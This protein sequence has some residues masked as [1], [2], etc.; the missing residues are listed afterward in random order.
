MTEQRGIGRYSA[1]DNA[2]LSYSF[3]AW[4]LLKVQ[5][6][7]TNKILRITSQSCLSSMFVKCA[8]H[9][10]AIFLGLLKNYANLR[11]VIKICQKLISKLTTISGLTNQIMIIDCGVKA[12]SIECQ[13]APFPPVCFSRRMFFP[14]ESLFPGQSLQDTKNI[15]SITLSFS[16]INVSNV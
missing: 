12:T 4:L 8:L 2:P 9:T 6:R 16:R 10:D 13:Q 7:D 11:A 15:K 14:R 1:Q 5:T 3:Q